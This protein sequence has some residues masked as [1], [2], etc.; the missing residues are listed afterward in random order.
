MRLPNG[1]RAIVD[2]QKLTAYC[3]NLQHT[4]GRH[5][6]RVFA[7]LGIT[8]VDAE[9]LRGA[10]IE[11]ARNGDALPGLPTPYGRRYT[12]DFEFQWGERKV[13]IRSAWIVRNGE[14]LPRLT[15]CYVL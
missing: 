4:R 7:S 1:E 5:K 8:E 12:I 13:F 3:L 2:I 10:L 6:A 15:T 14:D 9:A 11:A